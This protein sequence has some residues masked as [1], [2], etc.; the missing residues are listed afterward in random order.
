MRP[1][2]SHYESMMLGFLSFGLKLQKKTED[3]IKY[4]LQNLLFWVEFL[5]KIALMVVSC[6]DQ[7]KL[8]IVDD[9]V[10]E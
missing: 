5:R 7:W 2:N 10:I 1:R 8:T 4:F 9:Y 3:A 6:G